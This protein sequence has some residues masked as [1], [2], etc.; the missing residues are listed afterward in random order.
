MFELTISTSKLKASDIDFL[1][2]KLKPDIKALKGILVSEEFEGRVKLA[3][4]VPEE[5][6]DIALSLIFEGISEVIIRDYKYD[7]LKNNLK[8]GLSSKVT[9]SAFIRALSMYDKA[10]DKEVIK[11]ELKPSPEILIDS[12]YY[13]RLWELE[14]RWKNICTLLSENI[15]YLNVCGAFMDLM[16]FL[17]M[18]LESETDEVH[19]HLGEGVIYCTERGGRELFNMMYKAGDDNIKIK[20]LSEL[21]TL[22]PEKIVIHQGLDSTE[23][24]GDISSIFSDR[25]SLIKK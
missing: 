8:L 2:A 22:A 23:I 15:S 13:F 12:L 24:A 1:M 5:D 25:V 17:V 4:A 7:F 11:K 16:R 6:K 18:S 10:S 20:I 21:I 14:R 3:I 9:E 19:M